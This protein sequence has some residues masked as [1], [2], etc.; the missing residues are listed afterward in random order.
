MLSGFLVG[1]SA[2]LTPQS[3]FL[4][5]AGVFVGI[6]FGSIPGLTSTM[7]IALC[8]PMTYTMDII[9]SMALLCA[10]FIGGISGGLIPAI[11][12]NVPGTP[13]SIATCFDG[14]PMAQRGEAGRA[15]GIGVLYSFLGCIVSMLALFFISPQLARV[16][17]KFGPYEYFGV[18]VF[19]LTL[20]ASLSKQNMA[21]GLISGLLGMAFAFVGP[22]PIDAFPRYTFGMSGLNGGFNLLTALIGLFAISEIIKE[23][24]YAQTDKKQYCA[25]KVRGFGVT[26]HDFKEQFVNFIRSSVIGIAMGILPGVGGSTSSV[27]AYMVAKN[28]SSHPEDFGTGIIDGIV[29][30][31]SANN[32]TIGGAMIPLLTLGIPGESTTAMLLGAFM[33]HG[34]TPGPLLFE[35]NG[36]VVYAIFAALI[37]SNVVMLVM[38]FYGLKLFAKLLLIPKYILL[39]VVFA[40]CVVGAFGLNN[41][42]FDVWTVLFFGLVG[43][44]LDEFDYPSAPI[45]LGFI[46]GPIAETNLR[47]GL[48]LTNGSFLP[49]L[50]RPICLVFLLAAVISVIITVLSQL[51]TLKRKSI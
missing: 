49:F 9:P 46:L 16:A 25:V 31:E 47:S 36:D 24:R 28:S 22:A 51:K 10:I 33:I 20:I 7:A 41:R 26:L 42:I 35:K 23:A 4:M 11:L 40:L 17:I 29:A 18:A 6:I 1:F 14:H 44:A 45:I 38:E 48:M 3:L 43:F 8:L 13:S 5:V 21:K 39:P 50:K 34:L 15:M 27:L 32:A 37:I 2:M 19:S 12:I 30:S